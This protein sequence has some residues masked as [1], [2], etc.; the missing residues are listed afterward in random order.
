ME[1]RLKKGINKRLYGLLSCVTLVAGFGV[2]LFFRNLDMVLFEW[3]P[4]PVFIGG[5][6]VTVPLS[7]ASSLLLYNVPD[8]LWFLSGILF[9][10]WMWFNDTRWQRVYVWCFYGVALIL[11]TSQLSKTIPGTFDFL[12]LLFMGIGAFGEGLLYAHVTKRQN[13]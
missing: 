5:F 3:I 7:W 10:R 1:S 4:R 13:N 12:D 2:Y 9:L 11:E 8:M 6:S